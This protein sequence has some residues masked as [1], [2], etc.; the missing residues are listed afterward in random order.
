MSGDNAPLAN[1]G[2]NRVPGLIDRVELRF[3]RRVNA[4]RFCS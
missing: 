2:L 1:R 4:A 3:Q